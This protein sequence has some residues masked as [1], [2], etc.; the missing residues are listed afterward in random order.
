M[1]RAQDLDDRLGRA[2]AAARARDGAALREIGRWLTQLD[3]DALVRVDQRTRSGWAPRLGTSS[4]WAGVVDGSSATAGVALAAMHADGYLRERA[5]HE[6][7]RRREPLATHVLALRS[8]DHVEAVAT[9]AR[10]EVLRRTA[11][12]EL[13]DVLPVLLRLRGRSRAASVEPSYLEAV[14]ARYGADAVWSMVRTTRDRRLRREAFRHSAAAGFLSVDEAVRL[15]AYEHDPVVHRVLVHLVADSGS[16]DLVRTL[17]TSRSALGRVLALV[18][19]DPEQVPADELRRLLVDRSEL[20]RLWARRRAQENDLDA[21]EVYASVA[22]SDAAP[23]LRENAFRGLVEAGDEVPREEA[24]ALVSSGVPALRR[25]G[26]RLVR[27]RVTPADAALLLE[28]V[29]TGPTRTAR[30]AADALDGDT[31]R[32][33]VADLEPLWTSASATV[34]SRG[35]WLQRRRGGWETTVADLRARQDPDPL[36]ASRAPVPTPPTY[37]TPTDDQRDRLRVVLRAS[38]LDRQARQLVATSAGVPFA[39]PGRPRGL[40]RAAHDLD[41]GRPEQARARLFGLLHT[42]PRD[43]DVRTLL[44]RAYRDLGQPAQ[45][46]RWGFLRAGAATDE[47]C[48]AFVRHVA[49]RGRTY[50][51]GWT[52]STYLRSSL[53]RK[54]LDALAD[55]VGRARLAATEVRPPGRWARLLARLGGRRATTSGAR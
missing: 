17:L 30:L 1:Q 23:T 25:A 13:T 39:V 7:T 18:R 16:T 24:L 49:G 53:G 54:D 41:E 21:I 43:P 42:Y 26:L 38:P 48:A 46:G 33:S 8:T 15:T 22:R 51:S 4:D 55:D 35:W 20:V 28:I 40:E 47:E 5:V 32:W 36:V 37:G 6:L 44:A 50:V 14:E 27:G 9:L 52:M 2:G 34:R 3:A 19:L 29:R 10:E 12:H 11:M 45:A 31:A